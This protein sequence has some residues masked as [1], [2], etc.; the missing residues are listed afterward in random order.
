MPKFVTKSSATTPLVPQGMMPSM[1]FG[2]SPASAMA[3]S[4][5]C[6]WSATTL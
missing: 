3:A 1:S 4:A 2:V 5:A 6:I